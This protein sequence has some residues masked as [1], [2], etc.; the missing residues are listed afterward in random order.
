LN[1]TTEKYFQVLKLSY[2]T[3]ITKT[4]SIVTKVIYNF[5]VKVK[6]LASLENWNNIHRL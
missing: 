5:N 6:L 1:K 2:K 4:K 3:T